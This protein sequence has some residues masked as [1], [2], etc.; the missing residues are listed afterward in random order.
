MLEYYRI[1][2]GNFNI[3]IVISLDNTNPARS[4]KNLIRD[5]LRKGLKN[6]HTDYISV[7]H[8]D[9][10]I[11]DIYGIDLDHDEWDD[12]INKVWSIDKPTYT[13]RHIKKLPTCEG[14]RLNGSG[15]KDHM[16]EGGCLYDPENPY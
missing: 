13:A 4:K 12:I 14:C 6:Y 10:E 11:E 3:D 15:Q 9:N 16:D 5:E 2:F 8:S 7:I 1:D